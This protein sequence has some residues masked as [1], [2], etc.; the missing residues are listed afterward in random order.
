MEKAD[1]KT[2]ID[3]SGC[4]RLFSQPSILPNHLKLFDYQLE[5]LNWLITLNELGANGI[6]A[7]EMG[8]GKTIQ[9]I[10]FLAYLIQFKGIK[11]PHLIVCPKSVLTMWTEKLQEWLPMLRVAK[12]Q[13]I[14]EERE[15]MVR[16][17]IQRGLFDVCVTTY[18]GVMLSLRG[19]NQIP[20]HTLV[21]DEAQRIKSQEGILCQCLGQVKSEFKLL[22]TG[23]PVQNNVSELWSILHFIMPSLFNDVNVFKNYTRE[24]DGD[25]SESEGQVDYKN[26]LQF[27]MFGASMDTL[28]NEEYIQKLHRILAPFILRRSKEDAKLNLPQKIE[29]HV[30]CPMTSFQIEQYKNLLIKDTIFTSKMSLNNMCMHLRKMSIHPYLFPVLEKMHEDENK[31]DL[32]KYSGK[33][34]VLDKLLLKL[35]A[36]HRVLLFSQFTSVLDIIEDYL[37]LNG[38]EYGRIDGSSELADRDETISEFMKE[39]SQ[40]FILIISTRAGGLGLNLQ[41][42]DTVIVFDSDWNPQMDIQAIDRA[43]RIGQTKPVT[44]YRLITEHSIEEKIMER[45]RVKLKWD[46]LCMVKGKIS[47]CNMFGKSIRKE[48]MMSVIFHGATEIFKAQVE[49]TEQSIEEMIA[50]GTKKFEELEN[51]L[52]KTV[53]QNVTE[54]IYDLQIKDV[55]QYIFKGENYQGVSRRNEEEIRQRV[56]YSIQMRQTSAPSQ[57]EARF[58]KRESEM[59]SVLIKAQFYIFRMEADLLNRLIDVLVPTPEEAIKRDE[60]LG[61]GFQSWSRRDY[62]KFE[63]FIMMYGRGNYSELAKSLNKPVRE[64]EEYAGVF[65]SRLNEVPNKEKILEAVQQFEIKKVYLLGLKNVLDKKCVDV[66]QVNDI[67]FKN[68][69]YL[70]GETGRRNLDGERMAI[71]LALKIGLD[72][73]KEI[74]EEFKIV[75]Q[76]KGNEHWRDFGDLG[77]FYQRL[78]KTIDLII[79]PEYLILVSEEKQKKEEEKQKREEEKQKR[80]EEKQKREKERQNEEVRRLNK[81]KEIESKNL[82]NK[83][84]KIEKEQKVELKKEEEKKIEEVRK[85]NRLKEIETKSLLANQLKIERE[86]K[87]DMKRVEKLEKEKND[88]STQ[89]S[90]GLEGEKIQKRLKETKPVENLMKKK[91]GPKEESIE[92]LK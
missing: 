15:P 56:F 1:K 91:I 74:W 45:Q 55:S 57:R 76:E 29:K 23:T 25:K 24:V 30:Y 21:V 9:T 26:D 13:A 17:I 82:L 78:L 12:L 28:K 42:A 60:L 59:R 10:S 27:S 47:S 70:Q 71:Y 6:L 8:L 16:N 73:K 7:D 2:K 18:E 51:G 64:V 38:Y 66:K 65:W 22:L 49:N 35:R 3:K 43:H 37:I 46:K 41:K 85:L 48:D 69:K 92:I 90:K 52:T 36:N 86:Q 34:I 50:N 84:L 72:K 89:D 58:A 63:A 53:E 19:L 75:S 61:S 39:D 77:K 31:W 79:D 83:Q 4:L 80:E 11:G 44:I 40:V 20:W 87:I 33:M 32:I 67:A 81:L 54:D 62:T 68:D 5:G 14:A 88:V